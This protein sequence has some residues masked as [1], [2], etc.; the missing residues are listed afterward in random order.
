MRR[1]AERHLGLDELANK[2]GT[3]K[4]SQRHNYTPAYE[5]EFAEMRERA[6]SLVEIGVAG[7]ASLRMWRDWFAGASVVGID[8]NPKCAFT[9]ERV[10]VVVGDQCDP[11]VLQAAVAAAG[12]ATADIVID[13][14][15]HHVREQ[16]RSFELLWPLVTPGGCYVIEDLHTSYW[17][18][19]GGGAGG[20]GTGVGLA[21]ELMDCVNGYGFWE[22]ATIPGGSPRLTDRL[23]Q[24]WHDVHAVRC[25]R[26]LAFIWKKAT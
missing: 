2:Y 7:G 5:Q 26:S 24:R 10:Q 18:A 14:G 16:L 9:E 25:Y 15:G 22:F 12:N 17:H 1:T 21:K 13:D 20:P 19:W 6:E 3:D 23:P 4:S 8:L 11:R